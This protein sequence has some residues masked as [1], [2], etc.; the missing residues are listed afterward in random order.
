MFKYKG[1][2][3][4][5]VKAA[6]TGIEDSLVGPVDDS[7]MF[8]KA[9]YGGRTIYFDLCKKRIRGN[10][11]YQ[12]AERKAYK[13]ANKESEGL[14]EGDEEE[15]VASKVLGHVELPFYNQSKKL[16]KTFSKNADVEDILEEY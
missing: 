8:D 6:P 5:L 7:F 10:R 4:Q 15:M 2:P 16:G 11:K 1:T 3:V 14:D 13:A 9:T 12:L